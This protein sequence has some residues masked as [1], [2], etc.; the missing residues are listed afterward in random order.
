MKKELEL[1]KRAASALDSAIDVLVGDATRALFAEQEAGS[2]AAPE[3]RAEAE[4]KA[5]AAIDD[6]TLQEVL[7]RALDMRRAELQG[8][9][10]ELG[11]EEAVLAEQQSHLDAI[12]VLRAEYDMVMSTRRSWIDFTVSNLTDQTLTAVVLDCKLV[13]PG[14]RHPREK[15]TCALEFADGL[16]PRSSAAART[17][18]GWD[19][20]PRPTRRVEARPIRAH[21]A[22]RVVLW[23]VPSEL[24]PRAGGRVGDMRI[25]VA[26]LEESM[27]ALEIEPVAA[28]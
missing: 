10:T 19:T 3:E 16:P 25:R 27:Q 26:V 8:L 7:A 21:G 18:V 22:D 28:P 11:A 13:E 17:L 14:S 20:E 23:Q 2:A 12:R 1:S 24:D 15:G 5:L 9:V 4:A 6:L